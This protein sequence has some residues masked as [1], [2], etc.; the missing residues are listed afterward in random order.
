MTRIIFGITSRDDV[1][2]DLLFYFFGALLMKIHDRCDIA[3][4]I[5]RKNISQ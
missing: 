2:F 5:G 1:F 4:D 3:G